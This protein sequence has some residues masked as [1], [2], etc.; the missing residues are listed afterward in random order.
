MRHN[1]NWPTRLCRDVLMTICQRRCQNLYRHE[2]SLKRLHGEPIKQGRRPLVR[3]VEKEGT[4]P[5]A[6]A[7][8]MQALPEENVR[9]KKLQVTAI[10]LTSCSQLLRVL[11]LFPLL[12]QVHQHP[13]KK[14]N[15]PL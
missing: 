11:Q 9:H 4:D 2:N 8:R 1:H 7:K 12:F 6:F 14:H 5:L 3:L 10:I 13:S 15:N